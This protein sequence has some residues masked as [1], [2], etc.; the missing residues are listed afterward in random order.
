MSKSAPRSGMFNRS[1]TCKSPGSMAMISPA[2]DDNESARRSRAAGSSARDERAAARTP[3]Q[4]SSET[5]RR[6]PV[7]AAGPIRRSI[8]MSTYSPH[9][10]PDIAPPQL[11][12]FVVSAR[13]FGFGHPV[14]LPTCYGPAPRPRARQAWRYA[15]QL[16]SA[17]RSAKRW[18]Q[19]FRAPGSDCRAAFRTTR[20]GTCRRR[21]FGS[22]PF[23]VLLQIAL[24]PEPKRKREER[25]RGLVRRD[26]HQERDDG[27]N[28][29]HF[30]HRDHHT[31]SSAQQ[32]GESEGGIQSRARNAEIID[33]RQESPGVRYRW[34]KPGEEDIADNSE[35]AEYPEIPS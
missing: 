11:N 1:V 12:A 31:E 18:P 9:D 20:H 19:S 35:A 22:K 28:A 32:P 15:R 16:H 17:T 34:L 25:P 29:G 6:S 2:A 5:N 3:R 24:K 14:T 7:T 21:A 33:P 26:I 10:L 4:S 8:R 27:Y 30:Y 23:Q 13:A